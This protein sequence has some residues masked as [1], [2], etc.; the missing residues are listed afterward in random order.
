MKKIL[1]I[2]GDDVT[3][4][5]IN[6]YIDYFYSINVDVTF[7]GWNRNKMH[8]ENGKLMSCD[9]IMS[10]GGFGS[11][12]LIFLYPIWMIKLFFKTLFAKLED[13]NII[14]VNFDSALPVYLAS[15]FRKIDYI[16]EIHDEFAL[17][18]KF[19]KFIK[20]VIQ[21]VDRAIM[22]KAKCVIHVDKNRVNYEK[23]KYIII[24]NS[25]SDYFN[26]SEKRSY[27]DID[28]TFAVIGNISKGRGIEHIYNFA[29]EQPKIN[30]LLVGKFYDEKMQNLLKTLD[31]VD[32]YD[33]MPQKDLWQHLS[34][35]CAIFSLYDPSLEIN[36]LA[37]SNK[38]YDAMM[39]GIPVITNKE[40]VNSSFIHENNI[41]IVINYKYDNT[42]DILSDENFMNLAKII[43]QNGRKL[44]IEQYQFGKLIKNNLIPLLK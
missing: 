39:M 13:E 29:K 11:K 43:G 37:A 21:S 33:Y 4:V 28:K 26:G 3:N 1:F 6:K 22:R 19:P 9:Y 40:V 41:G 20:K 44:Y 30:L 35:C 25:P 15:F 8:H 34:K 36:R 27:G 31:N 24:E 12:R 32:Y 17:S 18:Y 10:G 23:C 2:K 38:V 42:W 5:R 16:Y 14:V 7:W